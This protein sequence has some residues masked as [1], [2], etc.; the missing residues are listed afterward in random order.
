MQRFFFQETLNYFCDT[1]MGLEYL[2]NRH[3]IH[4]DLKTDNLLIAHDGRIKIADFGMAKMHDEMCGPIQQLGTC[5]MGTPLYMAPE[6]IANHTYTFASDI[7]ALGCVFYELC[8]LQHPFARA[9]V[10]FS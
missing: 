9:D 7:W 4:R 2:H 10:I 3:V 1:L 5:K 6:A 8:M